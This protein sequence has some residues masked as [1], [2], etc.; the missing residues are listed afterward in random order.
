MKDPHVYKIYYRIIK[1]EGLDYSK[2]PKVIEE[3]DEFR[4]II[5]E[6]Q[7]TFEMKEHYFRIQDACIAVGEY[8]KDWEILIGLELG[9]NEFELRYD[10]AEIID[11]NPPLEPEETHYVE[12]HTTINVEV[13]VSAQSNVTRA[14]FPSLPKDF[15]TSPD[16]ESMYLRYKGYRQGK[17]PLT[18]MAYMCLTILQASAGGRRQA[19]TKYN[20]HM[21]VLNKMGDLTS[22]KGNVEEARKAPIER[23]LQPNEKKWI[24]EAVKLFIRRVGE[25]AHEHRTPIIQ[26]TM[27]DLPDI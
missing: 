20:I 25:H 19:S 10:H 8:L 24:I 14:K 7:I 15:K 9:P 17:E 16:V 6:D 27:V 23:P 2:A 13:V 5:E 11:R 4:V 3:T 26:I 21:D 22:T 18:S 1:G 12:A